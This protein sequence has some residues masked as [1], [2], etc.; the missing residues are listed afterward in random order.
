MTTAP[1]WPLRLRITGGRRT[2]H[3][4]Q[5]TTY[6]GVITACGYVCQRSELDNPLGRGDCLIC[7][8]EIAKEARG[9][10]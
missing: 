1:E 8:R 6:T 5:M 4:R 2:H 3:A 10:A 7:L 9:G